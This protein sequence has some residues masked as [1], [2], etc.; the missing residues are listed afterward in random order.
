MGGSLEFTRGTRMKGWLST[1]NCVVIV[2]RPG[3]IQIRIGH[4]KRHNATHKTR[5]WP[6]PAQILMVMGLRRKVAS[7]SNCFS[8]CRFEQSK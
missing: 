8:G 7:L 5:V 6:F 2:M 1:P 3:G 4:M